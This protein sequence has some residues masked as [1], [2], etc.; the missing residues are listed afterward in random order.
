MKACNPKILFAIDKSARQGRAYRAFPA[1][2]ML[3]RPR[4][5]HQGKSITYTYSASRDELCVLPSSAYTYCLWPGSEA[6]RGRTAVAQYKMKR[7]PPPCTMLLWTAQFNSR[8]KTSVPDA[9]AHSV[10]WL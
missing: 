10:A 6:F 8:S 1:F 9:A 4:V 2:S 7:K 5:S 3:V